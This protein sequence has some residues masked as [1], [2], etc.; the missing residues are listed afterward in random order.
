MKYENHLLME[1]DPKIH[2]VGLSLNQKGFLFI[3]I[4][5][6]ALLVL[7]VLWTSLDAMITGMVLI[8]FYV[9]FYCLHFSKGDRGLWRYLIRKDLAGNN[10]A[11]LKY[12]SIFTMI[13]TTVSS[14]FVCIYCAH[15]S[16]GPSELILPFPSTKTPVDMVYWFWLGV[17]YLIIIPPIELFFFFGIMQYSW[18]VKTGQVM[19]ILAYGL[20]QLFW[21]IKIIRN[22]LWK[23]FFTLG[24]L[25]FAW[26]V[27]K[28]RMR[29]DIYRIMGIRMSASFTIAVVLVF[30]AL[31]PKPSSPNIIR[32]GN[33]KNAFMPSIK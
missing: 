23:C 1:K 13:M 29:Y 12:N 20:M 21:H 5:L 10:M 32:F 30:L 7:L 24:S 15:I 26:A 14:F 6:P 16:W 3:S 33:P 28:G 25:V 4:W 19:I 18:S 17:M 27:Y 11:K 22:D 31:Y 9:S 2:G 8:F